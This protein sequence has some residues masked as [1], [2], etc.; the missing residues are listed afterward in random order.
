MKGA[1]MNTRRAQYVERFQVWK[2]RAG[3]PAVAVAV[4][5]AVLALGVTT[6]VA[7]DASPRASNVF[8]ACLKSGSLSKVSTTAHAC[9]SGSS[10]VS[11]N[12][13]GPKG[14]KGAKGSIGPTGTTGLTGPTGPTGPSNSFYVND[15]MVHIPVAAGTIVSFILAAGSYVVNADL[16]LEDTSPSNSSALIECDLTVGTAT[17]A[18]DL[19]LLG[20]TSTPQNYGA[21][22]LTVAGTLTAVGVAKVSCFAGGKTGN[23]FALTA[24]MTA[25]ESGSLQND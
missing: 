12:K 16:S 15:S 1:E 5:C 10:A 22:S 21:M 7:A 3:R 6:A 11:W 23:T 19:G 13:T 2:S 24:A 14:A 9:P 4:V 17:D 25:V 20:P 18:V 8:H